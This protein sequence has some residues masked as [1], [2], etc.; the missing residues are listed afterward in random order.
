MTNVM[1]MLSVLTPLVASPVNARRDM[2][3]MEK[4]ALVIFM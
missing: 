4:L 2:K 3:E 1:F